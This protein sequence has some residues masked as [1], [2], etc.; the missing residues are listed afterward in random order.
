V[1]R[2]LDLDW[3]GHEAQGIDWLAALAAQAGDTDATLRRCTYAG[4]PYGDTDFV[5]A[6]S[7]RFGRHWER[8]RPRKKPGPA[9]ESEPSR[10]FTLFAG[11]PATEE[12]RSSG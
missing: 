10:Q 2:S 5:E 8:G 11:Q 9:A 3:W 4:R 6:L 12:S 7:E 1:S